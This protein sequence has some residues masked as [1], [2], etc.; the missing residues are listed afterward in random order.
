M[1]SFSKYSNNFNFSGSNFDMNISNGLKYSDDDLDLIHNEIQQD[2]SANLNK[3]KYELHVLKIKLKNLEADREETLRNLRLKYNVALR[4]I[5][6][7]HQS[8]EIQARHAEFFES[9][10][11]AQ[12]EQQQVNR[13]TQLY[14]EQIQNQKELE[15]IKE[16]IQE[17]QEKMRGLSRNHVSRKVKLENAIVELK[18]QIKELN[19][20]E[21]SSRKNSLTI[22]NERR[23]LEK[24]LNYEMIKYESAKIR[25][26]RARNDLERLTNEVSEFHHS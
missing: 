12:Q 24:Q 2:L 14:Q 3:E 23:E 15:S 13:Q 25:L 11:L 4:R 26:D 7:I 18:D 6:Q 8:R 16:Q 10:R 20:K 1:Y 22:Y 5:E 19:N 9:R 21:S 17:I